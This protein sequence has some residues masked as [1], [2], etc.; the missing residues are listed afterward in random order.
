MSTPFDDILDKAL[1]IIDDYKLNN[2]AIVN[3]VA[4][5]LRL[6]SFL[7][8]SVP[9]FKKCLKPRTYDIEKREFDADFDIDEISIL[10]NL[11]V[12]TW[13]DSQIND[14][15]QFQQGLDPKTYKKHSEA[16]NLKEKSM[17][18]D[19]IR[20]ACSQEIMSYQLSHLMDGFMDIGGLS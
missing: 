5:Q 11:T 10:A 16:Q 18:V 2:L 14:V 9:Y 3:E 6:D 17:H 7:I 8:K 20:E 19:K 12:L 13:W 4:F 1:V 15:T